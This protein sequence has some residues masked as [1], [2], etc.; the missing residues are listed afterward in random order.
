MNTENN[1][2]AHRLSFYAALLFL[3]GSI[4]GILVSA[5]FTEKISA[6]GHFMLASHLS[7]FLG[8]F[9]LLGI[10][11]TL[12]WV[13]LSSGGLAW[14]Y[15]SAILA[16]FANWLVTLIKAFLDVRG[17]DATGDTANDVI[18][19]ALTLT[20]VIPTLVSAWLWTKGLRSGCCSSSD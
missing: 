18:F 6:N 16:A 19:G 1:K 3:L 17:I 9:W 7:G 14:L 10:A 8:C 13:E 12:R 5:A 4:T 15:K 20:V 11:F 2:I